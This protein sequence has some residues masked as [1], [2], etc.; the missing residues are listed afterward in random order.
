MVVTE[1]KGGGGRL[2]RLPSSGGQIPGDGRRL[3]EY[4]MQ[5]ADDVV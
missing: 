3:G 1:G 4:I 2:K 5:Y